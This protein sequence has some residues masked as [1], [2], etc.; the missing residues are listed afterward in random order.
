MATH[1]NIH[2]WRIPWTQ[3]P[4]EPQPM[5]VAKS[6][7]QPSDLTLSLSAAAVI[8]INIVIIIRGFTRNR[9]TEEIAES[10]HLDFTL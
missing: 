9:T 7:T 5:G 10:L 3:E 8:V 4:G 2:A 6:R 1:S